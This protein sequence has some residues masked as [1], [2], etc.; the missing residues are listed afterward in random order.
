MP[1]LAK[2][3]QRLREARHEAW[4]EDRLAETP[5]VLRLSVR[6]WRGPWSEET[7]PQGGVLVLALEDAPEERVLVR[8]WLATEAEEPTGGTSIA[9]I[10]VS[11]AWLERLVVGFVAQLLE[12]A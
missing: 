2:I 7:S 5:P 3:A 8:A 1:C 9:P 12:R 10:R 6:P 11:A 4:V